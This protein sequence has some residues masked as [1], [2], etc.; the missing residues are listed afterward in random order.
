M[1]RGIDDRG[2]EHMSDPRV[3]QP[4]SQLTFLRALLGAHASVAGDVVEIGADTWA[5]H[6]SIP[7][8]GDVIMAEYGSR[9][10]ARRALDQLTATSM[11]RLA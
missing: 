9:D 5:I 1:S 7:V 10:Q 6:G 3:E 8:D 11:M 4:D 2:G